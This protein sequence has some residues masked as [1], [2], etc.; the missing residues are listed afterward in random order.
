[1]SGAVLALAVVL[2]ATPAVAGDRGATVAS[3][4]APQPA[5]SWI[6]V[7]PE[8]QRFLP[9]VARDPE[10]AWNQLLSFASCVQ[11]ASVGRLTEAEQI[12]PLVDELSEALSPALLL[13]LEGIEHG[14]PLIKLRAAYQ[15]AMAHVALTTRLRASIRAP[16]EVSDPA[17][18][19]RYRSL[20][21]RLE[22]HL[23]A[24]QQ[25]AWFAFAVIDRVVT[26]DPSLARDPVMRNVVRDAR[27]MLRLLRAV[28]TEQDLSR[29]LR[30][31]VT[32]RPL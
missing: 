2:A 16:L 26:H 13:Y 31:S 19:T 11:D 6:E 32:A 14:P 15:A 4:G 17:D 25:T 20:H 3:S 12:E 23:L 27:V 7:S 18:W 21:D 29:D 9:D 1:M 5:W 30:F 8:C 10:L 22:P 28:A 24:A